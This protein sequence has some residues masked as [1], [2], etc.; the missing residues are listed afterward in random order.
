MYLF[1]CKFCRYVPR[2]G[3]TGSYSSIVT[4]LRYLH[5]VFH[6]G[7]TNLHSY[8]LCRRVPFSLHPL[9]QLLFVDLL[10]I[11]ILPGVRW[12]LKVVLICISL[13]TSDVNHF[14]SCLLDICMSSLQKCLFRCS[15]HFSIGLCFFLPLSPMSCLYILEIKPLSVASF[16]TIFSHSVSCLFGFFYIFLRQ[17]FFCLLSFF[18]GHTCNIWRF[19][20]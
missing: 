17:T 10:M 7:C 11:A 4:F 8:Q 14:F 19:P 5:T 18:K 12:Y 9:Q 6:S 16:E 1:Q 2:N 20:S 15:A 13:I 3:I